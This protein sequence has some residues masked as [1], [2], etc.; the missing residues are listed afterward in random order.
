MSRLEDSRI[1]RVGRSLTTKFVGDP[2]F[3]ILTSKSTAWIPI[4]IDGRF[5]VVNEG[6]R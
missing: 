5:T 2:P 3:M 1:V 6:V 4:S